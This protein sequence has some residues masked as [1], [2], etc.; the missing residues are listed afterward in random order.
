ML[1]RNILFGC[2]NII[3]F[4]VSGYSQ[5]SHTVRSEG[6]SF[7]VN[8]ANLS[9][10]FIEQ[11]INNFTIKDYYEFTNPSKDASYKL[12][13]INIYLAIPQNATVTIG[14]LK[15]ESEF[16]EK[17]V[18]KLNPQ[19]KLKD[20]VIIYIEREYLESAVNEIQMPV[21]QIE[22]Y[23]WFREFY[24]VQI[25]VNNYHFLADQSKIEVFSNISFRINLLPQYS[26]SQQ[27][28]LKIITDYDKAVKKLITNWEMAE[29]FRN[30]STYSLPD[31]TG[32][33]IDYSSTYL[34]IG[35][36]D[37]AVF[38]IT[39]SNLES[40]GINTNS[41]D[42]RTFKMFESG[43]QIKLFVKGENDG[44]F[45]DTD[46]IEFW[47]HQNYPDISHRLIN[48]DDKDYNE[49]LNRYTDT[50][51]FFLNWNGDNGNRTD[52][53]SL[54][55]AGINDTLNY[56]AQLFH[57]EIQ[58]RLLFNNNDNIA[59]ET[60]GWNKIKPGHGIGYFQTAALIFL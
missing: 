19:A 55:L 57:S 53:I 29:Q 43:R 51:F 47:G 8:I 27:S 9:P 30:I 50:T 23:F 15:F 49:Y 39:K 28:S 52:F 25:K 56:H 58:S 33:W 16:E 59:N 40:L 34:K 17:A 45:D 3:L 13:F 18:P 22:N 44:V 54:P 35:T 42:P 7:I 1:L 48:D 6:S 36:G 41:I 20:S 26:I 60:S 10:K 31:T 24:I 37:D 21:I 46:F 14:D 2:L 11:R 5:T 38:R 12:P 4:F 32:N